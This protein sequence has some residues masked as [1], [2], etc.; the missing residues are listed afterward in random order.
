M[1]SI[2]KV[3]TIQDATNSNTA[4]SIDSD[5]VV[6]QPA[7]PIL[8][9]QTTSSY[10]SEGSDSSDKNIQNLT[11]VVINRGGFTTAST[12]GGRITVPKTGYYDWKMLTFTDVTSGNIRAF[13][14]DIHKNGS[15]LQGYNYHATS[16]QGSQTTHDSFSLFDTLN[17][18][19]ND[20]LEFKYRVYN[21]NTNVS[22]SH[23]MHFHWIP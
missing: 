20:Y 21:N 17:L 23:R 4:L 9:I 22:I 13:Q 15:L 16:Y 19:A 7:N 10:T 11:N 14:F 18:N 2:L 1:A 12:N 3:N 5:G 8:K 6:S